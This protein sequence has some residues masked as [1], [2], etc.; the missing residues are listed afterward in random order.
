MKALSILKVTVAGAAVSAVA[1]FGVPKAQAGPCDIVPAIPATLTVQNWKNP[2]D[3][4]V[5]SYLDM[6]LY[7]GA[8]LFGVFD[9]WC[10]DVGRNLENPPF[11]VATLCSYD[12]GASMVVDKPAYLGAV[13]WLL[14]RV[15]KGLII[16]QPAPEPC[17]GSYTYGDVQRAIWGLL[18]FSQ[19][20]NGL[21]GPE[22]WSDCRANKLVEMAS[23]HN[24]FVPGCDELVGVL[25]VP[26]GLDDQGKLGIVGQVTIIMVP[27]SCDEPPG[28]TLTPG[29]WKTH[30]EYGPAPYDDTWEKLP[31]NADTLFF[32]SDQSYYEV[33]WTSPAGGNAYYILAHA[34]I[35]AEL[36]FFNGANPSAV[37]AAFDAAASLLEEFTPAEVA[38]LRGRDGNAARA[39]FIELAGV[40]DAYNN[41]LI[42]PGHCVDGND[43]VDPVVEEVVKPAKMIPTKALAPLP[44]PEAMAPTVQ[45]SAKP[46]KMLYQRPLAPLALD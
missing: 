25:L 21:N 8:N 11:D 1:L 46:S 24:G 3:L 4:G 33:L 38:A 34:Y 40:L 19:S 26:Y 20:S 13:N 12:L 9:G 17:V 35:A 41:G 5:P 22:N 27:A 44:Q 15:E 29:Y 16:G 10:V 6:W 28:C 18:D 39:V 32:L 36:N 45:P 37:Q 14:N 43:V 30:S 2:G 31:D 42:G 7:D 23:A